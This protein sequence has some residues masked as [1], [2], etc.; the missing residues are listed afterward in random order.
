MKSGIV[1]SG[2]KKELSKGV[3][4]LKVAIATTVFP[5][6]GYGLGLS[7]ALRLTHYV[8]LPSPTSMVIWLVPMSVA[9]LYGILR[10]CLVKS[11][12]LM[13]TI[14]ALLCF[15]LLYLHHSSDSELLGTL[16]LFSIYVIGPSIALCCLRDLDKAIERSLA[17]G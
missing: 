2:L 1:S 10:Q 11:A 5:L 6:L 7:L 16:G 14:Q 4:L 8:S 3:R 17:G 13:I 15:R 12:G 9:I